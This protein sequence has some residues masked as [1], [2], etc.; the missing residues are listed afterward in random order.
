VKEA[1]MEANECLPRISVMKRLSE[2]HLSMEK[3]V[4]ELTKIDGL[5]VD[6]KTLEKILRNEPLLASVLMAAAKIDEDIKNELIP[7]EF[8]DINGLS[9]KF[10]DLLSKQSRSDTKTASR[11]ANKEDYSA[12]N[13]PPFLKQ[14][15]INMVKKAR[16][17]EK[18]EKLK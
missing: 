10:G 3:L 18:T 13:L 17:K 5:A 7:S 14:V 15:L 11:Q 9:E 2:R 1:V 6:K 8:K 4:S 12:A 16:S